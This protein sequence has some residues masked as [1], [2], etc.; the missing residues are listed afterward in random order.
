MLSR[1]ESISSVST[2]ATALFSTS[3]GS[4]FAYASYSY[5]CSYTTQAELEL[6]TEALLS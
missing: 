1:S 4:H 6:D 2:E 3:K 5:S